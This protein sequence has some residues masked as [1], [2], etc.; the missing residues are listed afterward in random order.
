MGRQ[1]LLDGAAERP[2]AFAVDDSH[3]SQACKEGVVEVL[4]ED[5][6]GFIRGASD[7]VKL[8]GHLR[9]LTFCPLTFCPLT[10]PSPPMGERVL[11]TPFPSPLRGEGRVSGGFTKVCASDH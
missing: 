2:R 1:Q 5:V 7:Q 10:L 8:R 11:V 4:L 3:S 6:P 9:P